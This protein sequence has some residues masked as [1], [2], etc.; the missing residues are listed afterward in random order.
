MENDIYTLYILI[1]QNVVVV[2]LIYTPTT[3]VAFIS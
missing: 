1:F 3:V 2:V